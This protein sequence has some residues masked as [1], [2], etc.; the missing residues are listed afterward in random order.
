MNNRVKKIEKDVAKM[1]GG[2]RCVGSGNQWFEKSDVQSDVVQIEV[3]TTQKYKDVVIL[4]RM[5]ISKLMREVQ[6]TSRYPV[7]VLV[8]KSR[9]YFLVMKMVL[10]LVGMNVSCDRVVD[11][12]IRKSIV[13]DDYNIGY[14]LGS[15]IWVC[16]CED[17]FMK[18][19]NR[20]KAF[21]NRDGK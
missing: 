21:S 3:K 13:V 12:S 4:K 8:S 18:V 2:K 9:K 10:N 17:D 6:N 7:L 11:M 20:L 1:V 19:Y 5:W 15:H 14:K 16:M